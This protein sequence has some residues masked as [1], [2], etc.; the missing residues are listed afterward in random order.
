MERIVIG[1]EILKNKRLMEVLKP[2]L[3][4]FN[5]TAWLWEKT[6]VL[7]ELRYNGP[8]DLSD[9]SK[10]HVNLFFGH[11]VG[12]A[13]AE[14]AK[15]VFGYEPVGNGDSANV[16]LRYYPVMGSGQMGYYP[17]GSKSRFDGGYRQFYSPEGNCIARMKE[18]TLNILVDLSKIHQDGARDI[19]EIILMFAMPVVFPG[20]KAGK[21]PNAE[22]IAFGSRKFINKEK[23]RTKVLESLERYIKGDLKKAIIDSEQE[24]E[25]LIRKMSELE[26]ARIENWIKVSE[27]EGVL[28]SL[29]EKVRRDSDYASQYDLVI[30]I[31][32]VR[33][34][35][36]EGEF[37]VIY[38]DPIQV[39]KNEKIHNIGAY[40][41]IL[42]PKPKQGR[43][44]IKFQR[45]I[46]GDFNHAHIVENQMVCFGG[47]LG[48][49]SAL[50]KLMQDF[51]VVPIVH[52]IMTFLRFEDSELKENR[53]MGRSMLD[54]DM[55]VPAKDSTLKKSEFCNF[56][57]NAMLKILEA[58]MTTSLEVHRKAEADMQGA[59][60]SARNSFQSSLK[61]TEYLKSKA[62]G[63]FFEEIRSGFSEL[64]KNEKSKGVYFRRGLRVVA[65]DASLDWPILIW[66]ELDRIP[67]VISLDLET[68]GV[69]SFSHAFS[70]AETAELFLKI[71]PTRNLPAIGSQAIKEVFTDRRG[72]FRRLLK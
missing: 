38:T 71:L 25:D 8:E 60:L 52:L 29:K 35:H 63:E 48:F 36:V 28:S 41:I 30:K 44:G 26:R 49:N 51:D 31:D 61:K 21:R 12:G 11:S 15:S 53:S 65:D 32:G 54:S 27:L 39:V 33:S 14:T 57:T 7:R 13:T 55:P 18:R 66:V 59:Y 62:D 19:L 72:W 6:I 47:D 69:D 58:P 24:S 5:R 56:M 37:L 23:D 46:R 68:I 9:P 10:M 4:V 17:S 34:V 40:R 2:L 43:Q 16:V 64:E 70:L 45:Y 67:W 22:K 3:P 20:D 50:D 1:E 42:D